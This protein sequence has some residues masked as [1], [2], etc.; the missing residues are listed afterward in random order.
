M[1]YRQAKTV[2]DNIASDRNIRATMTHRIDANWKQRNKEMLEAVEK[3]NKRNSGKFRCMGCFSK[4]PSR[5]LARQHEAMHD[6]KDKPEPNKP[7]IEDSAA[8]K[9]SQA[10]IGGKIKVP[11]RQHEVP[12]KPLGVPR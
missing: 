5:E 8:H 12:R 6:A 2:Y 10:E 4:F 9:L 3:A 1:T 11:V 7:R